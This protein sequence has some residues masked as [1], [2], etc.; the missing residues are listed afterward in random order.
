MDKVPG[1]TMGQRGTHFGRSNTWSEQSRA[2]IAYVTRGQYILQQ[3]RP[4]A[5]VLFFGGES[6]PN[7]ER[8]GPISRP[9][10][11]TTMPLART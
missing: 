10:A 11:T 8:T 9:K 4:T 3:G 6:A 1:M 7:G 5:D 2:W